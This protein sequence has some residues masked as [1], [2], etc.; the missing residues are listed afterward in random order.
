MGEPL[1]KMSNFKEPLLPFSPQRIL[2]QGPIKYS[3]IVYSGRALLQCKVQKYLENV[4][5]PT[6]KE[7]PGKSKN[8]NLFCNP[9]T[10]GI[11]LD[12]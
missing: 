5:A 8:S 3:K 11:Y 9:S 1:Q 4:A 6:V 10:S 7:E 2:V 12:Y